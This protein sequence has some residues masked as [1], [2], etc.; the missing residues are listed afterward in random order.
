MSAEIEVLD[1]VKSY[2]YKH[3]PFDHQIEALERSW[4]FAAYAFFMEMGTG[5]TKVAIDNAGLLYDRGEINGTFVLCKKGAYR[6]WSDRE[7]PAHIPAH[8]NFRMA[9]W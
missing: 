6:N 2:P 7:I 8:I 4:H 9:Y 1:P 5:K 3:K